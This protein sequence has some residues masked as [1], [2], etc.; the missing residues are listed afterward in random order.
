M[1]PESNTNCTISLRWKFVLTCVGI[2][3]CLQIHEDY[4]CEEDNKHQLISIEEFLS[5][6]DYFKK[7]HCET[8][9]KEPYAMCCKECYDMA[10]PKCGKETNCINPNG[11]LTELPVAV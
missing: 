7:V 3:L 11:R 5:R 9:T 2:G 4:F 8:H 1:T 6:P 10:C